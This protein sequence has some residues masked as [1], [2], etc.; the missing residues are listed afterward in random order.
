MNKRQR[1][2]QRIIKAFVTLAPNLHPA[3]QALI[4][5]QLI[6]EDYQ[7]VFDETVGVWCRD[8][9]KLIAAMAKELK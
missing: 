2:R 9:A 7:Y 5:K 1:Q 8:N 6:S 3:T 4:I